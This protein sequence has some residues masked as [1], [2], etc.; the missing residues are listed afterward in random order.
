METPE[1]LDKMLALG[2]GPTTHHSRLKKAAAELLGDKPTPDQTRAIR[3]AL[4]GRDA[5]VSNYTARRRFTLEGVRYLP[6]DPVDM[7][8]MKPGL[9]KLLL[10][11]R[12][13]VR[14]G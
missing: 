10:N 13:V 4:R 12:R 3:E 9:K 1:F 5:P 2:M 7:D 14:N 8:G 11:Q 6:G